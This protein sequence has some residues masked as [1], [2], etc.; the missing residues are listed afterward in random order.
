MFTVMWQSPLAALVIMTG[1]KKEI[2]LHYCWVPRSVRWHVKLCWMNKTGDGRLFVCSFTKKW[3]LV[4]PTMSHMVVVVTL[5][6]KVHCPE[7]S[8]LNSNV[9]L[10]LIKGLGCFPKPTKILSAATT[11]CVVCN[12]SVFTCVWQ[13]VCRGRAHTHGKWP[14]C[15]IVP[16]IKCSEPEFNAR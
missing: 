3:P 7:G 10:L 13:C 16:I 4:S 15:L 9:S 11:K 5:V 1:A 8:T 14:A 2:R 12:E 6:T